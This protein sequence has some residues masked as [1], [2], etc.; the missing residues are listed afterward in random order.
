MRGEIDRRKAG[1]G[2]LADWR[3]WGARGVLCGRERQTR[4]ERTGQSQEAGEKQRL[5]EAG[6]ESFV[7]MIS[8]GRKGAGEGERVEGRVT[9]G[10]RQTQVACD[11]PLRSRVGRGRCQSKDGGG[12]C[13]RGLGEKAVEMEGKLGWEKR[14]S[15]TA[16]VCGEGDDAAVAEGR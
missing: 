15:R 12:Q 11:L 8:P 3:T 6:A 5:C 16:G 10:L 2:G 1:G 13:L 14:G 9:G 7:Q 4:S